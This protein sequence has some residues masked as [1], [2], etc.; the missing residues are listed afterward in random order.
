MPQT[1]QVAGIVIGHLEV[2]FYAQVKIL[3]EL[4]D[5]HDGQALL[6]KRGVLGFVFEGPEAVGATGD[7]GFGAG[8]QN[9]REGFHSSAA[10]EGQETGQAHEDDQATVKARQPH[11]PETPSGGE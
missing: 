10:C 11:G 8:G 9:G 6:L 7:D 4:G 2:G 3:Q 1:S 5:V